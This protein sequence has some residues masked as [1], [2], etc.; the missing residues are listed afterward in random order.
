[1]SSTL[2]CNSNETR[3]VELADW[4]ISVDGLSSSTATFDNVASVTIIA[5]VEKISR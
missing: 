3:N 1:M 2:M 4:I 5:A